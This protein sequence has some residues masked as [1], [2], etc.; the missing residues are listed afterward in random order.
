MLPVAYYA[1]L[2]RATVALPIWSANFTTLAAGD[3]SASFPYQSVTYAIASDS[4]TVQDGENAIIGIA[5]GNNKPR[6]GRVAAAYAYALCFEPARTNLIRQA[7]G[8]NDTTY[9]AGA[10]SGTYTLTADY[11][12]GPDGVV[13]GD[14]QQLTTLNGNGRYQ[15]LTGLTA[16]AA[17]CASAWLRATSGTQWLTVGTDLGNAVYG[18]IQVS[19]TLWRRI[20]ARVAGTLGATAG[21]LITVNSNNNVGSGGPAPTT[22]DVIADLNQH[23]RGGFPSSFISTTTAAVTRAGGS[24]SLAS[25]A[26]VRSASGAFG[27]EVQGRP[28][29]VFYLYG[30]EGAGYTK[31][32]LWT[33]DANNFA[34]WDVNTYLV[35]V[36]VGGTTR[37]FP[38]TIAFD[39]LDA[40]KLFVRAGGNQTTEGYF[41]NGAGITYD[42]GAA[43]AIAGTLP[44]SGTTYLLCDN[45]ASKQFAMWVEYIAAWGDNTAPAWTGTSGDIDTDF[46]ALTPGR[47]DG[48]LPQDWLLFRPSGNATS[49]RTSSATFASQIPMDTPRV[50]S[51]GTVTGL[52]IEET[53]TNYVADS[54][55]MVG[56]ISASVKW[57]AGAVPAETSTIAITLP[58]GTT[59]GRRYNLSST[60]YGNY[61]G[62]SG[63]VTN[64]PAGR[65]TLSMWTKRHAGSTTALTYNGYI[66][67]GGGVTVAGTGAIAD[68]WGRVSFTATAVLVGGQAMFCSGQDL[69]G[70]GGDTAR[71]RDNDL[72]AVQLEGGGWATSWIWTAATTTGTR[73]AD[74]LISPNV[75]AFQKAG[76]TYFGIKFAPQ[77]SRANMDTTTTLT[78][79]FRDANN[80]V[81]ITPS[82][83]VLTVVVLGV[84]YSFATAVTWAGSENTPDVVDMWLRIG[85]GTLPT[86]AK[87][88]VNG[89]SVV[90]LGTSGATIQ[91]VMAGGFLRVCDGLA[92]NMLS[93]VVQRV[94]GPRNG[95]PSW[96]AWA[97]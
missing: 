58:D 5:A 10:P 9:W 85:G 7:R 31:I 51:N 71:A 35:S 56:A 97:A 93:A 68:T 24:L 57:L 91:G 30:N 61:W 17:Y 95:L 20:F 12:A 45:A 75:T 44:V 4:H 73:S 47:Y 72:D 21:S 76:V 27:F 80:R 59:G 43:A 49:V 28:M 78:L 82:T 25:S 74:Q 55:L 96:L 46:S 29:G 41:Q 54:R 1:A 23:E 86:A 19:D 42:L 48:N 3:A 2:N 89:G 26:T 81:Y 65:R 52:L 11:A 22:Y 53:R 88:R 6:V 90:D 37:T 70:V 92:T 62:T 8:M 38:N 77:T 34:E 63:V 15:T 50:F 84:S 87:Y 39:P 13:A 60:N 66:Y 64:M 67:D 36:T 16:S 32:R 40:F 79:F 18:G 83:G 14:R 94:A 33:I 69:S